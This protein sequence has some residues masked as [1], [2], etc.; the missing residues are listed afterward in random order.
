MNHP[1]AML[2]CMYPRSLLRF[3]NLTW[4]RQLRNR[5]LMF[6]QMVFGV[7]SERKNFFL[8]SASN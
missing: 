1:N 5:S 6:F 7:M 2:E 3:H 4:I 8:S